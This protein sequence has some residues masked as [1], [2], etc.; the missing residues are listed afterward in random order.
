MLCL[1]YIHIVRSITKAVI[2]SV[3]RVNSVGFIIR[4]AMLNTKFITY[5]KQVIAKSFRND[6]STEILFC[7]YVVNPIYISISTYIVFEKIDV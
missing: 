4:A 5:D 3:H 1:I 2:A 7:T 6:G